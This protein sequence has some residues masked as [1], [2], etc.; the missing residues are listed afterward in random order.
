MP[1]TSQL[2]RGCQG[3]SQG[4]CAWRANFHDFLARL[5]KTPLSSKSELN[6]LS[7]VINPVQPKVG[8]V[9]LYDISQLSEAQFRKDLKDFLGLAR[10]IPPFPA[11]DTSGRFDHLPS[12]KHKT[13]NQKI[14][15][16]DGEH[17][18]IRLVLMKKATSA[19]I[20]IQDYFLKSEDVFVSNRPWFET[21]LNSWKRDPCG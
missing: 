4:V 3:G 18:A 6:L 11:I 9:F 16:C 14:D 7:L 10:D 5:G 8:P 12:I 15:I 21:V 13:A 2:T 19:S 17:D 20:W 1:P